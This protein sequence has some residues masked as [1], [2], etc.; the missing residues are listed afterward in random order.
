MQTDWNPKNLTNWG[1][2]EVAYDLSINQGC[3]FYKLLLRGLPHHFKP[4]SIYVHYPMTV[5]SENANIMHQLGRYEDYNWE[6]PQ[7]IPEML[8]L[9]TYAS[10]KYL[11][12]DA[13]SFKVTWNEGLGS[14]FGKAGEDFCLGGDTALHRQQKQTMSKLLYR[15]HWHQ[16]VKEFYTAKTIELITG[17]SCR[18][19]GRYQVDITRE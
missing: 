16:S 14:V 1:F 5:P 10:A 3:V 11:L 12:G 15:E 9:T 8:H 17:H 18:I 19:A 13:Q 4:D 2:G 6:K 7:F